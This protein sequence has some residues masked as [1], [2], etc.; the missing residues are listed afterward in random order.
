MFLSRGSAVFLAIGLL[1][2]AGL[3]YTIVLSS[4]VGRVTDL[5]VR[6]KTLESQIPFLQLDYLNLRIKELIAAN[7][8]QTIRISILEGQVAKF[9]PPS[10]YAR[11]SLYNFSFE[12]PQNME[13]AITGEE[14]LGANAQG[15]K[16]EARTSETNFLGVVWIASATNP[17]IN[18]A[19]NTSVDI[20]QAK[21]SKYG[22]VKEE[23]QTTILNGHEAKTILYKINFSNSDLD[24]GY[25]Y[26][27]CDQNKILYSL[28]FLG[29]TK[30][31]TGVLKSY[32]DSFICHL[33]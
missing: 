10:S 6:T 4:Y 24:G 20:L 9:S 1:L 28:Y 16:I 26:W 8:A 23:V 12:Y 25:C 18:V 32:L 19:L 31:H 22:F 14:G 29:E 2:G 5:E 17:D 27:Y 13:M 33:T 21:F 30:D 3:T 15:G 11:I 7:E